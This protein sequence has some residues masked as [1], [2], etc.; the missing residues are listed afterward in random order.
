MY[1]VFRYVTLCYVIKIK[2]SLRQ[3]VQCSAV[4]CICKDLMVLPKS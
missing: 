2:R 4:P 1:E 3:Y